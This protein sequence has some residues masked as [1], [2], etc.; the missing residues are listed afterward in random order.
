[1]IEGEKARE[2]RYVRLGRYLQSQ[3]GR[4][5][6]QDEIGRAVGYKAQEKGHNKWPGIFTDA[7]LWNA[8]RDLP[9]IIV[10]DGHLRWKLA[11]GP[12]EAAA[13]TI[14]LVRRI[15]RLGDRIAAIKTKMDG[16]GQGFIKLCFDGDLPNDDIFFLENY[17]L[18]LEGKWEESVAGGGTR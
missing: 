13:E 12:E 4:W 18:V 15:A 10:R 11:E 7:V 1:M 9:G 16:Q 14:R 6:S 17:F 5:I 3:P 2:A 8:D